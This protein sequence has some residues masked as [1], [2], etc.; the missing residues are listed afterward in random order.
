MNNTAAKQRKA[1]GDALEW[2]HVVMLEWGKWK[3]CSAY[4]DR[5]KQQVCYRP[6]PGSRIPPGI[7]FNDPDD[8]KRFQYIT[9]IIGMM[10]AESVPRQML[11]NTYLL[12]FSDKELA[13]KSRMRVEAVQRYRL[14]GLHELLQA[15]PQEYGGKNDA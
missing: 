11:L 9:H 1:H 8:I 7:R 12:E 4:F 14:H 13:L 5:D 6:E 2:L 3:R 15:L 10:N